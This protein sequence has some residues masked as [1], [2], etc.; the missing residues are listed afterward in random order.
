MLCAAFS[1]WIEIPAVTKS[2]AVSK[3]GLGKG[4]SLI[5]PQANREYDQSKD[6]TVLHL[7]MRVLDLQGVPFCPWAQQISQLISIY[8][9]HTHKHTPHT[10]AE[11]VSLKIKNALNSIV[12]TMDKSG[13]LKKELRH[14][15]HETISKLRKL[16]YIYIYIY[17]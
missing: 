5:E 13:N 3:F 4:H 12:N 16:I 14:E 2:C 1:V 9:Y 8:L 10:M 7:Q 11:D 15:F 6:V 17:I